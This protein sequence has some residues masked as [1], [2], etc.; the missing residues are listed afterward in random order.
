MLRWRNAW[1]RP[2][3]GVDMRYPEEFEV[4]SQKRAECAV[5]LAERVKEEILTS[6]K[7]IT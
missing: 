4:V 6:L 7:G 5:A 2:I 1:K 3:Y